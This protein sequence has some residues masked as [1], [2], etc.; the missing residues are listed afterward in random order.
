M[1]LTLSLTLTFDLSVTLTLSLTLTFQLHL[2][3]HYSWLWPFSI[4][5]LSLMLTFQLQITL[6]LT[7]TFGD[8]DPYTDFHLANKCCQ[9][10]VVFRDRDQSWYIVLWER[11]VTF[12]M[13]FCS[14]FIILL[15]YPLS[16]RIPVNL[17]FYLDTCT[18]KWFSC[19]VQC[20]FVLLLFLV[21]FF[22][23][24]IQ[25]PFSVYSFEQ[26]QGYFLCTFTLYSLG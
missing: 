26:N 7:L 1:T 17:I 2:L 14:I 25:L 18:C 10:L 4:L 23:F 8:I 16:I 20:Y 3:F 5:T 11:G 9:V 15:F 19:R 22:T 21:F 12:R 24:E 6:S 13:S